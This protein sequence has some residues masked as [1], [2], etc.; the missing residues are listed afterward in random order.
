MSIHKT[1]ITQVSKKI[2][3]LEKTI[4]EVKEAFRLNVP[5]TQRF[6]ISYLF[7]NKGES[8]LFSQ[9]ETWTVEEQL[10]T[11]LARIGVEE[12]NVEGAHAE[13]TLAVLSYFIDDM[14]NENKDLVTINGSD[15]RYYIKSKTGK[16]KGIGSIGIRW[17]TLSDD[18][19]VIIHRLPETQED[20]EIAQANTENLIL[21]EL[22]KIGVVDKRD[23]CVL[24]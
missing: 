24:L 14:I 7:K 13:F 2:S 9:D 16:T 15:I 19:K 21:D 8:I 12:L 3:E 18:V 10:T 11:I 23:Y 20:R 6:N 1:T 22:I 5:V 17:K 4:Q